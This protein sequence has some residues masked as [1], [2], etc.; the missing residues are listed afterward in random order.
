MPSGAPVEATRDARPLQVT[1][2]ICVGGLELIA[3]TLEPQDV[4]NQVIYVT[5]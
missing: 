5:L 1:I 3:I 2:G 4:A